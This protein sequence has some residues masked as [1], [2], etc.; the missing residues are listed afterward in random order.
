[1]QSV[2][3]CFVRTVCWVWCVHA[4]C[5]VVRDVHAECWALICSRRMLSV[6][7]DVQCWVCECCLLNGD[8]F[9][10]CY[11][12]IVH[13]ACWVRVDS[14]F[15]A[16]RCCTV[17]YSG[18]SLIIIHSPFS[19]IRH[20]RISRSSCGVLRSLFCLMSQRH[21]FVVFSPNKNHSGNS[22]LI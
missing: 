21:S 13:A 22:S 14:F 3:C 18:C 1:M 7:R 8:V 6:G 20:S 12:V 2:K 9:I 4:V 17:F 11:P 16:F 15:W 5:W 19:V 10:E